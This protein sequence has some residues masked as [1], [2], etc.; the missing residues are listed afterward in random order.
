MPFDLIMAAIGLKVPIKPL[1]NNYLLRIKRREVSL[2]FEQRM[3]ETKAVF[4][5]FPLAR[6]VFL[7]S[8]NQGIDFTPVKQAI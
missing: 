8:L 7:K 3:Q 4:L 2:L 5:V 1:N 6:R